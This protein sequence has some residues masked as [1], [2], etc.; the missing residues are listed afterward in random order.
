MPLKGQLIA[1]HEK[2]VASDL[3]R[4]IRDKTKVV[5]IRRVLNR[6]FRPRSHR[7]H[8]IV[9][10]LNLWHRD[11]FIHHGNAI[12]IGSEFITRVCCREQLSCVPQR[13]FFLERQPIV[14]SLNATWH[15]C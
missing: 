12:L 2:I 9:E 14:V 11:T 7:L 5:G 4:R 15:D 6:V 1:T 3:F 13:G 10:F 8:T